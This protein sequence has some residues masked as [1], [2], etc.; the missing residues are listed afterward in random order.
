MKKLLLVATVG[1]MSFSNVAMASIAQPTLYA[2]AQVGYQDVNLKERDEDGDTYRQAVNGGAYSLVFGAHV[3]VPNSNMFGGVEGHIGLLDTSQHISWAEKVKLT[4]KAG[5]DLLVG[6]KPVNGAK[7]YGKLGYANTRFKL[8]SPWDSASTN[9]D[10][11]N[12]G[13]G[14]GVDVA[15]QLT[16]RLEWTQTRYESIKTNYGKMTPRESEAALGLVYQF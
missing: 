4:R 6:F 9:R 12:V 8:S 3:D 2:G 5:L 7:L 13:V 14:V 15:S 1:A 10:G 16:A 11:I